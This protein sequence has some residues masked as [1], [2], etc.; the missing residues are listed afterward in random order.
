VASTPNAP[1]SILAGRI[2]DQTLKATPAYASIIESR[3]A[4]LRASL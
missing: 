1:L 2:S 4:R 3:A